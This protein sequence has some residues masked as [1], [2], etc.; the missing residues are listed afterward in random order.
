LQQWLIRPQATTG[1]LLLNGTLAVRESV[2]RIRS[3][4]QRTAVEWQ[5]LYDA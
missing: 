4:Q 1:S 3:G 2:R 5:G